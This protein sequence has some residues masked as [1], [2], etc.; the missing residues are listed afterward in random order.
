MRGERGY[1]R[2]D[3]MLT[4]MKPVNIHEDF[5]DCNRD[6]GK[7]NSQKLTGASPAMIPETIADVRFIKITT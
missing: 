6:M 3:L 1:G 5:W 2:W 4:L 7:K